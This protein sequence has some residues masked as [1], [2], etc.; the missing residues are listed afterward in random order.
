MIGSIVPEV[1]LG[2]SVVAWWE[3]RKNLLRK[4]CILMATYEASALGLNVIPLSAREDGLNCV[5]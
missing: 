1:W 5:H 2:S 4:A 3:S